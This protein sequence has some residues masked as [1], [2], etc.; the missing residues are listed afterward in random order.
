MTR[1]IWK[2][3]LGPTDYQTFEMPRGAEVLSV[4]MQKGEP[5]LWALVDPHAEKT[6]RAIWSC[7]IG[8]PAAVA[9]GKPHLGTY[10]LVGGSLVIHVFDGGEV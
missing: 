8:G 9:V 4:Q 3:D 5:V 7:G 1:T 10:Q 2:Y 6:T